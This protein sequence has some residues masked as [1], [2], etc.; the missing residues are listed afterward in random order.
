M[1]IH[2]DRI[3]LTLLF[4]LLLLE[5]FKW[6]GQGPA[7]P[8]KMPTLSTTPQGPPDMKDYRTVTIGGRTW[9]AEN[10]RIASPG[11]FSV[12]HD[13]RNDTRYGR[14]YTWEEART[15]CPPGWHL[16]SKKE[17]ED[18]TRHLPYESSVRSLMKNG[19]SGF[20]AEPAGYYDHRD[21]AFYGT[22]TFVQFWTATPYHF[23]DCAWLFY[24][25]RELGPVDFIWYASNMDGFSVRYVMD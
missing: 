23:T 13:P 9:M 1:T 18:L 10:L 16:P 21:L 17:Y 15:L 20:N 2:I 22:G 14:L 5:G 8:A 3:I 19:D 12:A 25:D 11:S 7:I 6:S 24:I 4:L